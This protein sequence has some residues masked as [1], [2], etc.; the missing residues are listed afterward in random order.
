LDPSLQHVEQLSKLPENLRM[1]P[2]KGTPILEPHRLG[3][4]LVR[5]RCH[6]HPE[7]PSLALRERTRIR[8][9]LA[10]EQ[11]PIPFDALHIVKV[12]EPPAGS[13]KRRFVGA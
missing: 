3:D 12:E 8:R 9:D 6:E 5:D 1:G 13:S 7:E 4:G 10:F 11:S 2:E